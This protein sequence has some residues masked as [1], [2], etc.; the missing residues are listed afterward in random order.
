MSYRISY[1]SVS[2]PEH[3]SASQTAK[4]RAVLRLLIAVII[5][6][7][8][9]CVLKGHTD[10]I[11]NLVLPGDPEVTKNAIEIMSDEIKAG[12]SLKDAIV[13]FCEEIVGSV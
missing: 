12:S 3:V 13:A 2:I 5:C 7:I 11:L 9:V 8:G 4:K 1:S 6:V 10:T